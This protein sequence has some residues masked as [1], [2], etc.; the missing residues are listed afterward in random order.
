VETKAS[1]KQIVQD[2]SMI[3]N[4]IEINPKGDKIARARAIAPTIENRW[5][6]VMEN[7]E[8]WHEW[9][10]EI[11]AFPFAS[12]DDQVDALSQAVWWILQHW[13][14]E[15]ELNSQDYESVSFRYIS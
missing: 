11:I 14:V 10:G 2:L 12:N 15:D 5:L 8:W 3:S 6:Y 7:A 9:I 1:G 13:E 4:W